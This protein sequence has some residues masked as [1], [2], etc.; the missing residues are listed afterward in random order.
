VTL[1]IGQTGN[2][3]S[4]ARALLRDMR[5]TA[6]RFRTCS[7]SRRKLN[8]YDMASRIYVYDACDT[9]RKAIR[10]LNAAKFPHDAIPIV[11]EPPTP[12]ELKRMLGYVKARG[13]SLKNLF[14]TSGQV[15][16]ELGVGQKL[17][18][19]MT[20]AE[21]IALLAKNGKLIKRPFFLLENDGL[22]GFKEGEW[23]AR[24]RK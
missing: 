3:E 10:F 21:T 4:F 5:A 2:H 11:E 16:R 14:N 17:A 15:Y 7:A 9:C 13:G 23:K 19:G 1:R 24:I 6:L 12:S 22:V 8:P 20:E 18:A